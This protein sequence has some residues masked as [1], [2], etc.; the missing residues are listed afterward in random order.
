MIDTI[1]VDNVKYGLNVQSS[2]LP[3]IIAFE[4]EEGAS[5]RSAL[6]SDHYHCTT[7]SS[8]EKK[9]YAKFLEISGMEGGLIVAAKFDYDTVA[10]NAYTTTIEDAEAICLIPYMVDEELGNILNSATS[11][12]DSGDSGETGPS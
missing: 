3:L 4:D 12:Y 5:L 7:P 8:G 11:N 10:G 2:Q 6:Y 1:E 9:I